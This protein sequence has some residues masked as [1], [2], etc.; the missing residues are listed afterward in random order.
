MSD[1]PICDCEC[2]APPCDNPMGLNDTQNE[3]DMFFVEFEKYYNWVEYY[4]VFID[5]KTEK[6]NVY[7]Q[8]W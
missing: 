8:G 2:P 7:V 6:L 4:Q 1:Y 5:S 3:I